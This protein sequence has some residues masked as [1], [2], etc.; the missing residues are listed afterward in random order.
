MPRTAHNSLDKHRICPHAAY[1]PSLCVTCLSPSITTETYSSFFWVSIW[2]GLAKIGILRASLSA[3]ADLHSRRATTNSFV[4]SGS[5]FKMASYRLSLLLGCVLLLIMDLTHVTYQE[6]FTA[7]SDLGQAVQTG[8]ELVADL[9]TY[10]DLEEDRLARIRQLADKLANFTIGHGETASEQGISQHL[11][12]DE[13]EELLVS[14]PINAYLV[15]KNLVANWKTELLSLVQRIS[16]NTSK[17]AEEDRDENSADVDELG[18]YGKPETS[19]QVMER[20]S[21]KVSTLPGHE[22]LVG[23]ADAVLRLQTTYKLSSIDLSEG[24]VVPGVSSPKLTG[25]SA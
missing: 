7:M 11:P 3:T 10:A 21:E 19:R 16:P 22:D 4:R 23:A 5:H 9:Y 24:K 1:F 18:A 13:Q 12:K 8:H 25:L 17:E 20:I 2:A 14:N 15:V 6:I